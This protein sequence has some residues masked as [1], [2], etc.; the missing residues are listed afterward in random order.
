VPGGSYYR[1][2]VN[3]GSGATDESDPARISSFRLDKY[4]VTVGRFRQYV[5]YLVGGGSAP[6]QGSGKHAHLNGGAGLV[7]S[8]TDSGVS[9]E[10]GW[11]ATDWNQYVPTG[12][13]AAATW[14]ANLLNQYPYN[15]W[16]PPPGSDENLPINDVYW[17]EAY[18]F[19]IWDGGFLPSDAELGYAQAGG[20]QQRAYPWG[21]TAPGYNYQYAIYGDGESG[22]C[23]YPG[24]GLQTCSFN[25]GASTTIPNA[26]PVWTSILGVG[27]W[28]QFDLSGNEAEWTLDAYAPYRSGCVDC[29]APAL[30]VENRVVRGLGFF[31][32]QQDLYSWLRG[33]ASP[34]WEGH[35][36]GVRCA[37]AP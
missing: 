28:G 5:N 10:N 16:T 33:A 36:G 24:P 19:C 37:R 31:G 6:A 12:A 4:L 35:A 1:T 18:A 13:N 26:A 23:D 9:Y 14:N 17:W 27:R 22:D 34:A 3:L 29:V 11:D 2:Y 8:L 30:A 32:E 20:D 7:N 21:S 25:S 15:T